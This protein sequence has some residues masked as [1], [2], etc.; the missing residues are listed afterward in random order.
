MC[1]LMVSLPGSRPTR[2]ELETACFNNDDGFGYSVHH[3]SHIVSGRGMLADVTVER[4]MK[5]LDDNPDAIG[6]FHARLTTHGATTVENCH[7]FRVGGRKDIV[8]GHN[9]ILPVDIQ[10]NDKRSDTR[11]FAEDLL[12]FAGVENLDDP[13]YVAKLEKWMG[14]SKI[15]VL[16]T[17][18]ELKD[19]VYI[20][21]EHLGHWAN[22]IWWSNSSYSDRYYYGGGYS[23]QTPAI[24]GVYQTSD[25]LGYDREVLTAQ[26]KL[27][28]EYCTWCYSQLKEDDFMAG[29]CV[30]CNTCIDCEEQVT[31]CLCYTP[32]HSYASDKQAWL[33]D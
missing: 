3:G 33:N 6:M 24:S 32:K 26:Y 23:W 10:K 4:F 2:R 8:L 31:M 30:T 14:S 25:I 22:G 19:E 11:V 1:L 15:A 21:N 7:P 29:M 28:I 13:E 20:L 18:P 17:A 27:G 12:P 5:E 9:G 16:S